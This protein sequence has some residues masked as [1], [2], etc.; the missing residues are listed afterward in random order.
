M[1]K[2]LILQPSGGVAF[3]QL[4]DG[5][6][7]C[8]INP[9]N[10]D[11]FKRNVLRLAEEINK[12]LVEHFES[13]KAEELVKHEMPL[14]R[15][16]ILEAELARLKLE[17]PSFPDVGEMTFG[18]SVKKPSPPTFVSGGFEPDDGLLPRPDRI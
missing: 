12:Y 3:N 6:I 10:A 5:S 2:V 7:R 8:H 1:S 11:G 14:T 16:Q 17:E 18:P 15:I 4:K 9:Q 13:Q